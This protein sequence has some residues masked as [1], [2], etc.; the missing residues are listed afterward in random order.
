ME[1][2]ISK[3][4]ENTQDSP[5]SE[6][7]DDI[8]SMDTFYYEEVSQLTAAG[9][10][11]IDF[12]NK[13][14]FFD[15]QARRILNVPD[16]YEPTL[17]TGYQFYA[18]EHLE[19]A[20]SFF[21]DCAQGK[22]FNAEI[23]MLTYDKRKF[24]V[25]AQGKPL[26]NNEGKIIGIRGVFQDINKE[27]KRRIKLKNSLEIIESQNDRLFNFAHIVS[28][29]LRSHVSNMQL[30][31]EIFDVR[32]LNDE[33]LELF[34]NF[35]KIADNLEATIRHLNEVVSIQTKGDVGREHVYIPEVCNR[36]ISTLNTEIEHHNVKVTTDFS[37]V[38][39]I[40]YIEA[41]LESILHNLI[42][43]AVKYRSPDRIAEIG[44]FTTF[45]SDENKTLIVQDNGL[46]IDLETYGDKIFGMY[47]TFHHN[48]DATGIGLF[49]TKNQ[50]E[51]LGG[52]ITVESTPNQGTTFTIRF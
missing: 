28:H 42:T 26:Y 44:I 23:K 20:T 24:W 48:K 8:F 3:P 33:Q 25:K 50:I 37:K 10:W 43:N 12:E 31:S 35:K 38:D 19:K 41:Y 52:K 29:N 16:D 34:S 4:Q 47:K 14:S 17:K 18:E 5:K 40:N 32:S 6:T 39:T 49:I 46:G 13:R 36:V 7:K 9:G 45:D 51:T 11:S 15:K 1:N 30:T 22:S 2:P 27:K 21:F